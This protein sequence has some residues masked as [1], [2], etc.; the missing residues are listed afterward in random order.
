MAKQRKLFCERNALFF[1]ISQKKGILLR[2]LSDLRSSDRFAVTRSDQPLPQTAAERETHLI[3]RAP[4]VDL[5]LQ[6]NKAVNI[7]LASERLN[8]L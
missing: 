3:K 4:G 8:G 1:E 2:R 6:E 5:T 7:R